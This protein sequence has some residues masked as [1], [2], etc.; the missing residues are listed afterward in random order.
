MTVTEDA[1]A[2]APAASQPT[3]PTPAATGLAAVLGTGDHKV[4][5]RIW[6]TAS[7]VHLVVAG[8]AALFVAVLR[9]DPTDL[10]NDF[11]SQAVSLRS[12]GGA[13]L[14]LLPLTIGVATLVV[15]LQVG[16]PTIAFP[17]AAAAAAWTYV[18]GG[19]LVLGAYAIDGGPF[20]GD[21]DGVRLFTVAFVLVLLALAVAW[22]CLATTVL[23][24]RPAGM[25]LRRIPLFAW[26][27]LVAGTVWLLTLPV[28]A[29]LVV[30]AY[31][32][33]RYG[34]PTGF[35]DG[36]GAAT[37]YS[38]IAWVFGQPAVYAFAIPVLGIV[39]SVVPVLSR[40]R[41]HQHS[42]ALFLI[43][44]YGALSVG[45][46]AVPAFSADATPWVY[47][48]PWVAVS[49]LVL[50]PVLGL[51]GLWALTAR[52]GRPQLASPLLFGVAS[53]LMLLAGLAAGAVQ[54]IEPIE[55]LVDGEGA[56]LYGTS[57]TSSVASYIVLA[58]AIAAIGAVVYWAP[59]IFGRLVSENGARLVALLLLVGTVAWSLPDLIAGL[60]GQ[61]GFPG[62]P[63]TDNADLI[64]ALDTVSA[65]GG[66]VLAL[67]SGLFV[68][69]LLG[70][71]RSRD[72]PG[73]DPWSGHTLEW[74]TS[75][76]PPA[77]NFASLPA[78]TSEAPLYD[79]RYAD[80]G[81]ATDEEARA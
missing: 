42:V 45:A 49:F 11:F 5:G 43:G 52:R 21:T 20:G 1:P 57:V 72:L 6:L 76:P 7:L 81:D 53:V 40:T 19:G 70:A 17:R 9:I 77:G 28:L 44:A 71:L 25:S 68:L 32:D 37:L 4:I 3:A 26:S 79:A 2:A 65:I 80:G 31:I 58:T 60:F 27:T 67:G 50:L 18:L 47:E 23:A 51:V 66:G 64:K 34:G 22:I 69:L 59:K 14:F 29:G 39:G 73:D 54:A 38:R 16:A 13:F 61:P 41:H 33:L 74:A 56:S 46:W 8:A 24:L 62:V 35:I 12:I 55:T 48:A 75:S 36:G 30:V 63:A 78:I 15:P 10:D